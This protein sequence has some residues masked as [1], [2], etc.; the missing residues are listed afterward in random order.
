MATPVITWPVTITTDSNDAIDFKED[1]G[2]DELNATLD[3]GTY[4]MYG[5]DTLDGTIAKAIKDAMEAA[6]AGTYA[7][8]VGISTAEPAT[9]EITVSG[10][11]SAV[12]ITWA[13]GSNAATSARYVTGYG[14]A[15]T[16]S[17]ATVTAPNQVQGVFL[18]AS[19]GPDLSEDTEERGE[20]DSPQAVALS[21]KVV[22]RPIGSIRYTRE[23]GIDFIPRA[24]M[25]KS[26]NNA[27]SIED[28]WEYVR[29]GNSRVLRYYADPYE[30]ATYSTYHWA[31]DSGAASLAG[32]E[33]ER[34]G[35]ELWSGKMRLLKYV[36]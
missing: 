6:G 15:D 31:P 28:L 16:A 19:G 33:R 9:M 14:A 35:V 2:V 27:K 7:V 4:E 18:F 23:I 34:A 8:D 29:G 20:I 25:F 32:W 36:S 5:A 12:Q 13:N 21:G 24:K 26:T 3:A 11:K 22:E 1:G 17:A 30:Q 10:A